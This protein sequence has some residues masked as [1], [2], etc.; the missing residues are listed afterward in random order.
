MSNCKEEKNKNNDIWKVSP[1]TTK[2]NIFWLQQ[3]LRLVEMLDK[4]E[5]T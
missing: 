3:D 4:D 1:K 5:E 2:Q